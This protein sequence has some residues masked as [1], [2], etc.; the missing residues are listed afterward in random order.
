MLRK[1][2]GWSRKRGEAKRACIETHLFKEG[3]KKKLRQ[4]WEVR[5]WRSK[6]T[7]K[8][9]REKK[10]RGEKRGELSEEREARPIKAVV[11]KLK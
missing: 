4:T 11:E 5:Q 2:G 8:K 9:C 7:I 6:E 3:K 10:E 1:G